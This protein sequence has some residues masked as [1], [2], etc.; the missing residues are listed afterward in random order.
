MQKV[1]AFI[2][3][4]GG[5]KGVPRKNVRLVHGKPL[6]A[7]TI[8]TALEAKHLFHR[9]I[10]STDDKEIADVRELR[11]SLMLAMTTRVLLTPSIS[12]SSMAVIQWTNFTVMA[13]LVSASPICYLMCH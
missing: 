3:A 4:R 1:L 7:Y 8:E 2:P 6:I 5:S 12:T 11:T 13:M 10:V 9:I